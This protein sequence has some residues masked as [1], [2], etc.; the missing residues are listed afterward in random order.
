MI[1]SDNRVKCPKC[2]EVCIP[3]WGVGVVNADKPDEVLVRY[4]KCSKCKYM[5]EAYY[6][7]DYITDKHVK[8]KV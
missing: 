6:K 1:M 3:V 7:L 2:T 4:F 8:T 5:G